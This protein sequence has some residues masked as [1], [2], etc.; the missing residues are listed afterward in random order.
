MI[1]LTSINNDVIK[2]TAALAE[3]KF[4]DKTGLFLI[5]GRKCIEEAMSCGVE[6]EKVFSL[7]E[8][9]IAAGEKYLVNDAIL[10]K[11][12]TTS[13]ACEIVAVAK[14]KEYKVEQLNGKTIVLLE[15]VKDPGNIGTI[16]RT[17]VAL[18]AAAVILS[19]DVVDIYNPKIVRSSVGNMF[20]I[21]VVYSNDFDKIKHQFRNHKFV[22]TTL[23]ESKSPTELNNTNFNIGTVMMFGSEADGLSEGI[24]KYIDEYVKIPMKSG[25]E[26]LNVA[27]TAAIVLYKA[28]VI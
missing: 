18:G 25:V 10:K 22:G 8:E 4:R 23:D 12:S 19:G 13:S 28:L 26:S 11:I 7:K 1:E 6:I 15:N 17:A 16:I 21:P 24:Q 9:N 27:I 2:N 3:K 5:E 20:K 14:K